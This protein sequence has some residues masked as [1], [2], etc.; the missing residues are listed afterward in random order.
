MHH[1][2]IGSRLYASDISKG[3]T[4]IYDVTSI[5]STEPT[6]LAEVP[7]GGSSHSTW[8]TSDGSILISA[9]EKSDGDVVIFDISDLASPV[10]L[11]SMDRTS[12][13]LG[14][15]V[16][17]P[18]NPVLFSDT[19]LFIS[20]YEAGVIAIDISDPSNPTMIG[21]YDTWDNN[22]F[23]GFDGNW[24]VYPFLGLDRVLLSDEQ[25]GL[26]VVDATSLVCEK[27]GRSDR[28]VR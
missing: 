11:A 19:L 24:G 22:A 2:R 27:R 16:Y 6:L 7:T 25:N 23:F 28:C 14:D 17:S 10:F 20:W 4:Y 18:H 5:G 13:G 26:F 1:Q 21:Q 12:L 9:Q 3:K 15:E 8:A